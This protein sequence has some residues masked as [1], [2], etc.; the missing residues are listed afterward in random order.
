MA[1]QGAADAVVFAEGASWVTQQQ[2]SFAR[3][4]LTAR[5]L[6]LIVHAFHINHFRMIKWVLGG[7][8][9]VEGHLFSPQGEF[10]AKQCSRI[11]GLANVVS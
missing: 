11:S 4:R 3:R 8:F 10:L 5:V 6:L 7:F 9:I 1:F 2:G